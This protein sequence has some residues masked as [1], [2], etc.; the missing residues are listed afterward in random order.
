VSVRLI[1]ASASPR[2]AEILT[3][4]GLPH[5][6]RVPDTP[7]LLK[8]G[9]RPA[10]AARRLAVAKAEAVTVGSDEILVA[11]D[12]IVA[13]DGEALGKPTSQAEAVEILL[14]LSGRDHQVFTGMALRSR[15]RLEAGVSR[16]VVRF[17]SLA[18][19]ECEEYVASGETADKAGAYGIQG[20][21]S[22]LVERIDGDFF[23]VM[24]LPVQLLLQ[25]LDR[26][27]YRYDFQ[28]ITAVADRQ[29][30]AE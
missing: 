1:L 18:R 8:P 5:T 30:E 22:A 2:R 29:A 19:V 12:T 17:R 6:V 15:S 20:R 24:G 23:N 13:V 25:L 14:S 27:G 28:T 26:H 4:L 11:A 21:G 3:R 9:E 16:T 7:E 10:V